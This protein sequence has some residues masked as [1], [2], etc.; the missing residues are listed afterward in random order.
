VIGT[1]RKSAKV[2]DE[3]AFLPKLDEMG[4]RLIIN[5]IHNYMFRHEMRR[6]CQIMS[7]KGR[8]V[9]SVW[10][11]GG[12]EGSEARQPWTAFSVGSDVTTKI[13][14][15]SPVPSQPGVRMGLLNLRA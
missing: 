2:S 11:R 6:K 1:K 15:I 7:K 13:R 14:E 8:V 12:K 4:T 3:F 5:P 10:N 9:L